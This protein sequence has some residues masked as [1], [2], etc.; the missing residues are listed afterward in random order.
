MMLRRLTAVALLLVVPAALFAQAVVQDGQG[1]RQN[2]QGQAVGGVVRADS[3]MRLF[4]MDASGNLKIV[5]AT[6]AFSNYRTGILINNQVGA[7]GITMADSSAPVQTYD[8]QR[9][10]LSFYGVHDSLSTV[11]RLAVQVRAHFTASQD[12]A[13]TFPWLRWGVASVNSGAP[14]AISGFNAKRDSIGHGDVPTAVPTTAIQATSANSSFSGLLPG[15]FMVV[16]NVA[17]DDTT[18]GG[19]AG[20]PYSAPK[21]FYVPLVGAQGEWFWAPYMSIRVRTLNGVRSRFRVRIDYAG[22]SL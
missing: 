14:A 18:G 19:G 16:F 8:L 3:T 9:I 17:R 22:T 2:L 5:D 20:K 15:E 1:F 12:T 4:T 13:T 6:P 11:V 21:G 10:G 7:S